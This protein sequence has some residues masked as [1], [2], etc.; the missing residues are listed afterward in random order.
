[1]EQQTAR[2]PR[3]RQPR[4]HRRMVLIP[5]TEAF[6]IRLVEEART[7]G[8][9]ISEYICAELARHHGLDVPG[10][11]Q[12]SLAVDV[13]S[14]PIIPRKNATVR[15]P[16]EHHARYQQEADDRGMSLAEYVR[17]VTA[18]LLGFEQLPETRVDAKEESLL[19]A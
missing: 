19:S 12:P 3:G 15:V 16:E 1:M 9:G 18:A 17:R 5:T 13:S 7:Q 11:I 10:Y 2:R 6:Y 14:M 8:I 4:G